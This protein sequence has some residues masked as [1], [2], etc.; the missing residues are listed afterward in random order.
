LGGGGYVVVVSD[1]ELHSEIVLKLI[2]L[3]SKESELR[4]KNQKIIEKEI[5]V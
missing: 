5:K 1:P 2:V 4:I 3:G